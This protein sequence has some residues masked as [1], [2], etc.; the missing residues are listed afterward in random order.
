MLDFGA[1][2]GFIQLLL[3]P[4]Y[5]TGYPEEMQFYYCVSYTVVAVMAIAGLN[6]Y[7][8]L[9]RHERKIGMVFA[10]AATLPAFLC[11][12]FFVSALL[13]GIPVSMPTIPLL[14]WPV[15]WGAFIGASGLMLAGM[16][17]VR[18]RRRRL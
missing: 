5:L 10:G 15:V 1:L 16:A 2:V 7:V 17:A 18:V 6:L 3:V 13:N 14:P 8:V 4:Q 12:V 11:T 9:V